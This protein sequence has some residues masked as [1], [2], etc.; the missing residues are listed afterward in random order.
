MAKNNESMDRMFREKLENHQVKPSQLAWERLE[1]QL[2]EK[3][4]SHTRIYWWAA[5]AVLLILLSVGTGLW[6]GDETIPEEN[7]LTENTQT[8]LPNTSPETPEVEPLPENPEEE[9]NLSTEEKTP[10]TKPTIQT[11]KTQE[12]QKANKKEELTTTQ[13]LIAQSETPA[14]NSE[15][16]DKSKAIEPLLIE[17][18]IPELKPLDLNQ[19]VATV[20]TKT[21]EEP[22]YKVTIYSNGIKEDKNL[23]A[24]IGKKVNQVEG[25]LGKVDEGLANIQ[26]AKS[27]LFNNLTAKRDKVTE[28]E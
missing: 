20:E 2:P 1:N 24:G 17:K 27:N 7:L 25:F 11:P 21:E 14:A 16:E 9:N 18:E 8:E 3:E 10:E 28:E 23:I 15:K 13:N 12:A 22:A 5:A 6:S 4:K 19:A 26:D